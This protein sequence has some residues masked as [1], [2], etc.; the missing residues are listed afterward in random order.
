MLDPGRVPGLGDPWDQEHLP[1]PADLPE[2]G[3]ETR[4]MISGAE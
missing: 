1:E 2:P 4:G 3:A